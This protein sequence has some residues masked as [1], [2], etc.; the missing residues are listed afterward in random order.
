MGKAVKSTRSVKNPINKYSLAT[1]H[2]TSPNEE[3]DR[4]QHSHDKQAEQQE[5]QQQLDDNT[6]SDSSSNRQQ[7]NNQQEEP[8]DTPLGAVR[9]Y[10]LKIKKKITN[11]KIMLYNKHKFWIEP[12]SPYFCFCGR[13]KFDPALLYRPRI[14][15]RAPDKLVDIFCQAPN[16]GDK[17]H[18]DSFNCDL[19]ARR[20]VDIDSELVDSL[21]Y[22][23]QSIF[24][25]ILTHRGGIS[26]QLA[27]LLRP[28]FQNAMGL[29][30][31]HDLLQELDHLRYSRLQLTYLTSID[32]QQQHASQL[33]FFGGSGANQSHPS[34][35]NF[36]VP[37]GY[38]GYVP[39]ATYLR[40][41][42][43]A[44]MDQLRLFID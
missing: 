19:I 12:E 30:R 25:A 22:Y 35:S 17:L 5:Q 7:N 32:Y 38:A 26:T 1:Q 10:L 6:G 2:T 37:L 4:V 28:C 15:V 9:E 14:F 39:S 16:Y 41:I 18:S 40:M 42:Y 31:L 8:D 24:P 27:D 21:L 44:I 20:I 33:S 29:E 23:I 36:D 34:F 43:T 3:N 13:Q 11:N